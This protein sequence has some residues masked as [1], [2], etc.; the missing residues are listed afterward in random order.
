[1]NAPSETSP[2]E[3]V[4]VQTVVP[5]YRV[6]FF[7][8]LQAELGERLLLVSGDQDWTL[9]IAHAGE[10]PHDSAHNRFLL[11]RRLLW[12]SG[13]VRPALTAPVAVLNLNPRILSGWLVLLGRKARG[14]KT[15]LWGHVWP[16]AGRTSRTDRVRSVMRRL[17]DVLVVYTESEARAARALSGSGRVVAAP[18]ALYSA[19]ELE[20]PAEPGLTTDFVCVGRLTEE[21]EPDALLDAF[22]R[23]RSRLPADTRLVFVGDGPLRSSLERT[24]RERGLADRVLLA[25]HVSSP[26]ELR[27]IY[28]PAIASVS[29]GTAGLSV[30]QSLGFGVPTIVARRAR[31]GPELDAAVEGENAVF[32]DSASRDELAE[33]LVSVAAQRDAWRSRRVAIATSIRDSYTIEA[34]VA[35]F[36]SAVEPDH[37]VQ[38]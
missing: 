24:T 37:G 31:H 35:A 23:A 1:M 15:V 28:A 33:T 32:F 34:M 17:A 36:V 12:Q 8:A 22:D 25:G 2:P 20:P 29:P 5:H 7:Q 6:R 21:K 16:R 18:N 13:V 19:A 27:R 9:D 30:I 4:F 26:E 10:V 3:I 38:A 11:R 14:R